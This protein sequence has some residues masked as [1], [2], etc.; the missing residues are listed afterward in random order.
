VNKKNYCDVCFVGGGVCEEE[1]E[2]VSYRVC[3]CLGVSLQHGGALCVMY[4]SHAP[5]KLLEKTL[6]YVF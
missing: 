6:G 1:E 3:A 2:V 5:L 4:S